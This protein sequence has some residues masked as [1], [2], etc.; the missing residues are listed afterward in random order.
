MK[1]L[2]ALALGLA[3]FSFPRI[4]VAAEPTVTDDDIIP[5]TA[6]GSVITSGSYTFSTGNDLI[7]GA[8]AI[9]E[10][11]GLYSDN[12][13]NVGWTGQG[14]GA[15]QY[16]ANN[17]A[18]DPNGDEIALGYLTDGSY[19]GDVPSSGEFASGGSSSAGYYATYSLGTNLL[20]YNLTDLE[21]YSGWGDAGRYQ[22]AYTIEYSLAT[23]STVFLT[24]AEVDPYPSDAFTTGDPNRGAMTELTPTTAGTLTGVADV[25]IDFNSA[26]AGWSGYREFVVDGS[27]VTTTPEPSTWAMLLGG[28]GILGL[29]VRRRTLK[30]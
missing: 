18:D 1:L 21:V 11:H 7:L 27:P 19:G 6:T 16:S 9:A 8:T 2:L 24:L 15:G 3:A 25:Q 29:I 10:A 14:G 20:G 13:Y 26:V 4:I 23:A 30:S 28:A 5:V 12:T 17:P 22:Q